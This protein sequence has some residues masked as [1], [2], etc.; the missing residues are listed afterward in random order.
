[1]PWLSP[2]LR[3]ML[4]IAILLPS[5]PSQEIYVRKTSLLF[6][7]VQD[8]ALLL[9]PGKDLIISYPAIGLVCCNVW[10]AADG[11]SP[12]QAPTLTDHAGLRCTL[13]DL[14]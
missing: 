12:T 7:V 13:V 11:G 10:R 9:N 4:T 3:A 2:V 14:A 1:V 5:S 6:G 8:G